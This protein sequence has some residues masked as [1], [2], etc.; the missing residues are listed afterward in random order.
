MILIGNERNK[1]LLLTLLVVVATGFIGWQ[2]VRFAPWSKTV[3]NPSPE[4]QQAGAEIQNTVEQMKESFSVGQD[5]VEAIADEASKVPEQQEL[6]QTASEYI[7]D[8]QKTTDA[9]EAEVKQ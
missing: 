9:V 7:L 4:L 1:I 6:L 8:K 2:W 3:S 5:Q